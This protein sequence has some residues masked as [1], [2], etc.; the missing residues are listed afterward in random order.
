MVSKRIKYA[1]AHLSRKQHIEIL[2]RPVWRRLEKRNVH[3][4]SSAFT[5]NRAALKCRTSKRLKIMAQP[6]SINKKYDPAKAPPYV[7]RIHPKTLNATPSK[8]VMDL[9]LP[10]KCTVVATKR[11]AEGNRTMTLTV[12]NLLTRIRKSR[13]QR[14]RL[15][16][17]ALAHQAAAKEA[18]LQKKLHRAL[19][20][21][22]D[23]ERHN[24]VLERIA[25]PKTVP[26][27]KPID[28]GHKTKRRKPDMKLIESLAQPV[29]REVGEVRDPFRVAKGALNYKITDRVRRLAVR[30]N[31]PEIHAPRIPGGVSRAATRAIATPRLITL[32]KPAVR[33]AGL[34]TDLKEDAFSVP[35]RALK[36]VCTPRT[37]RLARPRTYGKK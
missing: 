22:S 26:K 3:C 11:F 34:V 13:Y 17:N 18:K 29:G 5:V 24:Q 7:P 28:T 30:K 1:L 4:L 2:A 21:P 23:W 35:P 9:A 19:T 31:P 33:P 20:K 37:K 36:A 8:R 25:Q 14:Y 15:L 10:R 6:R 12:E 27:P 32:A 16:C